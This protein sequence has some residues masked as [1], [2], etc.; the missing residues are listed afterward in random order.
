MAVEASSAPV[1]AAPA[2]RAPL[3]LTGAVGLVR[4]LVFPF[5]QDVYGDAI[6]RTQ[7]GRDWAQAPHWMS[8]FA[9][10]PW[11]FG[12]LHLYV[13]G[14]GSLIGAERLVSLVFGTLTTLPLYFLTRRLFSERAARIACL[15]FAFWGLHIQFST[16]TASE[17]LALFLTACTLAAF[18]SER[19]A[20]AGIALTL[21]CATRYDAWLL[22]PMLVGVL[23]VRR[24]WRPAVVLGAISSVF[25]VVWMLGNWQALGDPLYP[26]H[27]VDAFHLKWFA[28]NE[29]FWGM[30]RHRAV[31]LLLWPGV[32]LATLG[33]FVLIA[34]A[35]N[36]R[37]VPWL[38]FVM[39]VP[40]VLLTFRS[41]VLGTF[42]PI[43]RFTG[44]ELFILIVFA[45]PVLRARTA[46]VT[47]AL[48]LGLGVYTYHR[49]GGWADAFRPLSPVTTQ[50]KVVM[51]T[52]A[53]V[54]AQAALGTVAIE[55]DPGYRDLAVT[56]YSGVKVIQLRDAH[57]DV[58]PRCTVRLGS[59]CIP[60][61]V[62]PPSV[63]P[64][65]AVPDGDL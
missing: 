54:H 49:E 6:V 30:W 8:S 10:G 34:G 28:E 2:W 57:P 40:F 33:P 4:L 24:Q 15:V 52:A 50:P 1:E 43:G 53:F 62:V 16:T 14:L 26:I 21:S 22:V 44:R 29:A 37:R 55:A 60:P 17:A 12:P 27:F 56:F 64:L 48:A 39:L 25:P 45:A 5:A 31:C 51:E 47:A 42:E 18:A 41:V 23:A 63:V 11:Q 19:W 59:Q 9:D 36:A 20:L 38:M 7:M 32:A 35:L 58:A 61:S 13:V 3:V 65:S 46:L